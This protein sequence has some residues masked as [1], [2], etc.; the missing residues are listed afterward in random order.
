[1]TEIFEHTESDYDSGIGMAHYDASYQ[2]KGT[3]N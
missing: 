2:Q 3:F 1:M